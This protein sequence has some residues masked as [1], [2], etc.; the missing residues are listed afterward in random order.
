MCAIDMRHLKDPAGH[1]IPDAFVEL[2]Q[3]AVKNNS[4]ATTEHRHMNNMSICT[5]WNEQ[6]F[7]IHEAA[8]SALFEKWLQA[9]KD[10]SLSLASATTFV[11]VNKFPCVDSSYCYISHQL[12]SHLRI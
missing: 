12:S 11:Y 2:W 10:W 9:G 6:V 1:Q 5:Q 4:K 3:D 7:V 8:K